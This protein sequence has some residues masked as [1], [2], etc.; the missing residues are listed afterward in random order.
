M[1]D[2]RMLARLASLP[3]FLELERHFEEEK[4]REIN[5]LGRQLF[6]RPEEHDRIE[7]ER[8]KA[9]YAGIDSVFRAARKAAAEV[10]SE[11]R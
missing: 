8:L 1:A 7:A 10:Q 5:K 11:S 6:A 3:E 9:K 4:E 2:Q